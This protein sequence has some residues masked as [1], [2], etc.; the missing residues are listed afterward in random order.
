MDKE[1]Y[2][3]LQILINDNDINYENYEKPKAPL[4]KQPLGKLWGI[5]R[6]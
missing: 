5:I 1:I 3:K 4:K 2:K 6:E